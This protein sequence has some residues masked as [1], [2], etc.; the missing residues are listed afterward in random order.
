M[1]YL[2]KAHQLQENYWCNNNT[3][4]VYAMKIIIHA[5]AIAVPCQLFWHQHSIVVILY[6]S[7][8]VLVYAVG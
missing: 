4:E 5:P 2:C 6:M 7:Y 3:C 8:Y 1:Q